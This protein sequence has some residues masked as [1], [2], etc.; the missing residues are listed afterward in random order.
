MRKRKGL[1]IFGA[2]AAVLLIVGL[3]AALL[4]R[5]SA[6]TAF[7]AKRHVEGSR[8]VSEFVDM[9]TELQRMKELQ[10][11]TFTYGIYNTAEIARL[12]GLIKD[13]GSRLGSV[14]KS[15]LAFQ[16][17][18]AGYPDSTVMVIDELNNGSKINLF[19][20]VLFQKVIYHMMGGKDM[21]RKAWDSPNRQKGLCYLRMGEQ[22]NCQMNHNGESCIVPFTANAVHRDKAGSEKAVEYFTADLKENPDLNYSKWLLNIA[23]LTLGQ[24]PDG[25]P[26]EYFIDIKKYEHEGSPIGKFQNL[27]MQLGVN[28]NGYYGASIIDDFN[29]DGTA[30][31]FATSGSNSH[32]AAMYYGDGMGNW[33]ETHKVAFSNIFGGGHAVQGDFNNDGYLDIYMMRG[34]WLRNNIHPNSLLVNNGDGTFIDVT[35]QAGLLEYAP[36]HTAAWF[37]Y[38]MDGYLDLFV[39]SEK[40]YC[41]LY[42]NQKDGTF[43]E[44]GE[45]AG[46]HLKEWVKASFAADVNNDGLPDLYVSSYNAENHLYMNQGKDDT[47]NYH[48][49]DIARKAGVEKPVMSFPVAV[50]DFNNDGWQDIFCAAY[51]IDMEPYAN[52]FAGKEVDYEKSVLYI[53]KRNGTFEPLATDGLNRSILA[54]GLNFG[55]VDND[56]YEDLYI[57]TGFPQYDALVPNLMLRNYY[58]SDLHDITFQSGLGHLQKGHGIAFGDIDRDGDR[59][60]YASFGGFFQADNFDNALFINP[61]NE[62]SW[63]R[64]R[65]EGTKSN[66]SAIGARVSIKVHGSDGERVIH[67][68][69]NSGGSYGSSTLALEIGIGRAA[70]IKEINVYWPVSNSRQ[71]FTNVAANHAYTLFEGDNRLLQNDYTPIELKPVPVGMMEGHHHH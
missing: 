12:K 57:G 5:K 70:V 60:I 64:L 16:Y 69:V 3:D 38:N 2:I 9:P 21:F 63:V 71:S 39:G 22:L 53:N 59:D 51:I 28:Y 11:G 25:V 50:F 1:I 62:N 15:E 43:K 37:D 68:S 23:Y 29:N 66:R 19:Y 35:A 14:L 7:D 41:H 56:G 46:I 52:E 67:R 17:L 58:G 45:Q 48:F 6:Y 31:I 44:V 36:S 65:L 49:E 4:M 18:A 30:D 40:E 10:L 61:G 32:A 33:S 27:A 24:Y 55:D 26:K 34:G 20:T 42:L 47:G 8:P 13:S 54:M